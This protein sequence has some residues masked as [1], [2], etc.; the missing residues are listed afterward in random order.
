[1]ALDLIHIGERTIQ[2]LTENS[3]RIQRHLDYAPIVQNA[4]TFFEKILLDS[5]QY[6]SRS[7]ID[8]IFCRINEIHADEWWIDINLCLCKFSTRFKSQT[9][10]QY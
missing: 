2:Q 8:V 6:F 4:A 3:A 10:R 5:G 9:S 1:M 7:V